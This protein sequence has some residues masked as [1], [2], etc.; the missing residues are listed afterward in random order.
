MNAT[1]PEGKILRTIVMSLVLAAACVTSAGCV[2]TDESHLPPSKK[3]QYQYT[4]GPGDNLAI[5]IWKEEELS[6][7]TVVVSPDGTI[8]YPLVGQ[9]RVVDRTCSQAAELLRAKLAAHLPAPVVT[10]ELAESR[11]QQVQVLGEVMRQ[12]PIQFRDRM[13]LVEALSLVGG[14]IWPFAKTEEMRIVRGTLDD[15]KMIAIDL[16]LILE[17]QEKDVFLQ[18]GDIVVLPAKHVTR[19]DRYVRQLLA[20]LGVGGETAVDAG[21]AGLM[22]GTT[23]IAPLP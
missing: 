16:D 14:P 9:L 8:T 10:V 1:D 22:L 5:S 2:S 21:R 20:P 18:P 17:G 13:T 19:F 23:T 4:I 15:P 11:S 3:A 6:R 12:A 7:E